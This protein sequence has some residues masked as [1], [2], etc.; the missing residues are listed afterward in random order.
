[1]ARLWFALACAELRLF[2]LIL[3]AM[4]LEMALAGG[5]SSANASRLAQRVCDGFNAFR[6]GLRDEEGVTRWLGLT[7]PSCDS[8]PA[9]GRS[10]MPCARGETLPVRRPR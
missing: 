3:E 5:S 2:A 8:A 1:M 9:W 4:A 7:R 6:V 10:A